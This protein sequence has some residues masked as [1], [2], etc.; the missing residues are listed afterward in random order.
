MIFK[1]SKIISDN[2]LGV[3]IPVYFEKIKFNKSYDTCALQI[4]KKTKHK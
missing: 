1:P 3:Y 4:I 2:Q